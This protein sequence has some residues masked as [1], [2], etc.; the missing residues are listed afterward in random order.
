VYIHE[1]KDLN[2]KTDLQRL[3][4]FDSIKLKQ[5]YFDSPLS[6]IYPTYFWMSHGGYVSFAGWVEAAAKAAGK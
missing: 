6:R 2:Q 4:P 5:G 1:I 3:N